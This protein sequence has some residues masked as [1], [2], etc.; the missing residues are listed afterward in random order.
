MTL[1]LSP[2]LPAYRDGITE[3]LLVSLKSVVVLLE[4][5]ANDL[6]DF[7]QTLIENNTSWG[8]PPNARNDEAQW[9][10]LSARASRKLTDGR[11]KIRSIVR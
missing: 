2:C 8:I 6:G 11:F 10:A 7:D 5:T 3:I 9:S 4:T 1:L